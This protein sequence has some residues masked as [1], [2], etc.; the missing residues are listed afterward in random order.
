MLI[1]AVADGQALGE[2]RRVAHP[3]HPQSKQMV[4]TE[5]QKSL[6]RFQ[7]LKEA[8][9]QGLLIEILNLWPGFCSERL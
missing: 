7:S 4:K 9:G 3:K 1:E 5:R 8:F 6:E 2:T